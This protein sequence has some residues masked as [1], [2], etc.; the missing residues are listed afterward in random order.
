MGSP[1]SPW[2]RIRCLRQ[3]PFSRKH[4]PPR[5]QVSRAVGKQTLTYCE[6]DNEEQHFGQGSN[7][8]QKAKLPLSSLLL[9][10][11]SLSQRFTSSMH[12]EEMP[13]YLS[14]YTLSDSFGWSNSDFFLLPPPRPL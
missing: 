13:K 9:S 3:T 4:H 2:L 12:K 10:R 1:K 6:P 14:A 8:Q 11:G 7:P 5:R